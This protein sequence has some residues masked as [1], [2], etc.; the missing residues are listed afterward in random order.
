[1]TYVSE[2]VLTKTAHLVGV[3][4]AMLAKG[5]SPNGVKLAFVRAGLFPEPVA[6]FFV[7]EAAEIEF[8]KE[9]ALPALAAVVP[10]ALKGIAG[11]AGKVAPWL[12]G[13]ATSLGAGAAARGAGTMGARVMGLGEKAVGGLG[14][15]VEN[16]GNTFNQA[17]TNFTAGPGKALWGGAK[18]YAKGMFLGRG[19]GLGGGLGRAT[20]YGGL[21]SG[22]IRMA[23][24]LMG[25]GQQQPPQMMQQQMYPQQY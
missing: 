22:G 10:W 1:M 6:D 16:A 14:K 20:M 13:K 24:G 3:T 9:A 5:Y 8:T 23:K 12:A 18:N 17:A 19:E 11:L 7:K 4:Q 25:G 21:A 15:W 2:E